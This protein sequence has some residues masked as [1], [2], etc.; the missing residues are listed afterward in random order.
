[1]KKWLTSYFLLFALAGGV[2]A[3][4]PVHSEK[5]EMPGCCP[6][7]MSNDRSPVTSMARLCCALNCDESAPTSSSFSSNFLPSTVTIEDSI[8]AQFANQFE[9]HRY[10]PTVLLAYESPV[11]SQTFQPKYIQHHSFLI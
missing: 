8:S 2:M 7:A 10:V 4:M 3:G 6:K 1:M 5:M 9:T 11:V